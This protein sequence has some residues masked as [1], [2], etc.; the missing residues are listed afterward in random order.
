MW[1]AN[2]K[3]QSGIAQAS[4]S[5]GPE[6]HRKAALLPSQRSAPCGGFAY[7]ECRPGYLSNRERGEHAHDGEST[8]DADEVGDDHAHKLGNGY[9]VPLAIN[10]AHGFIEVN[11]NVQ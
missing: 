4:D 3:R 8:Q 9:Q 11:R 5:T 10:P 1:T 2:S 7:V 6:D